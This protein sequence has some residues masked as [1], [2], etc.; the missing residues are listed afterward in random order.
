MNKI[1]CQ[2]ARHKMISV[3]ENC[4]FHS[5]ENSMIFK[6]FPFVTDV[7]HSRILTA[8]SREVGNTI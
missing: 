5:A 8:E 6:C 3:G 7:N 2:N 4:I 1:I